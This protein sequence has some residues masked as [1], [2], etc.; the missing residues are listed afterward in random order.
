MRLVLLL[1]V[2]ELVLHE[3]R[4]HK[5]AH[6]RADIPAHTLRVDVDLPQVL[7]HFV[8]VGDIA[9]GARRCGSQTR[10]IGLV[11]GVLL[12]GR[13]CCGDRKLEA[14]GDLELRAAADTGWRGDVHTDQATRGRG[15]EGGGAVLDDAHGHQ[16]FDL[17]LADRRVLC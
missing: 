1:L 8:L 4:I 3:V 17:H 11:V 2:V 15:G 16:R 10:G 12:R 5:V 7:D 9:L 14:V 6:A 13:L